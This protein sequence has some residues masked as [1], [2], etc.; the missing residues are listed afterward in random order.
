MANGKFGGGDGTSTNPYLIED[1]DDLN[2]IRFK[3]DMCFKMVNDINL[4][5]GKY[6]IGQ[7]WNPINEFSGSF[8]GNWHKIVNLY[9]NRPTQDY[10][11]FFG[12]VLNANIQR[13]FFVDAN[14]IGHNDIAIVARMIIPFAKNSTVEYHAHGSTSINNIYVVN[15]FIKGNANVSGMFNYTDS[16]LKSMLYYN[17]YVDVTIQ[18]NDKKAYG[19]GRN[20]E[21]PG[22]YTDIDN[23][24]YYADSSFANCNCG[25]CSGH[26]ECVCACHC[27]CVCNSNSATQFI[28]CVALLHKDSSITTYYG[29]CDKSDCTY[30]NCYVDNTE[31]SPLIWGGTQYADL[32]NVKYSTNI[33]PSLTKNYFLSEPQ[34]PVK[35]NNLN[36]DSI[37]FNFNNGY[38]VYDFTNKKWDLKYSQFNNKNSI[39]IIQD[40]M[41]R[42][43][44]REIPTSALEELKKY[45]K[46]KII[47]CIYA[48]DKIVYTTEQ[49]NM[50]EYTDSTDDSHRYLKKHFSFK[51]FNDK[52]INV[53]KIS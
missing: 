42:H 20:R 1:A 11:A 16:L 10:V 47:D 12:N 39:K 49:F 28:N 19:I 15:S 14:V 23:Q 37:Y 18:S 25:V 26:C 52:I 34:K 33:L 46:I 41:D 27:N 44:L 45:G 43:K 17:L 38:Y 13:V 22:G 32:H 9:I 8:D 30:Q 48:H 4:A 50:N 24:N 31:V 51:D 5:D 21:S 3:S 7:G 2:A 40:G 6:N 53:Q 36:N 35:P 29:I